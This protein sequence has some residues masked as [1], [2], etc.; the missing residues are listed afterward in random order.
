MNRNRLKSGGR[1][2][3]SKS[4]S[5]SFN[6]KIYYGFEGDTLASALLANGLNVIARSFKYHRPRGIIGSGVE[7]P[8][9]LIE[10]LD[11]GASGNNLCTTVKL[12]EGLNAKSINCW[13]S[14]DFDI[15]ASA[16][17]F[18]K[19]IP[20][21]FYYK[22]FM[23]P[24]W[25]LFEPFIR[26]AAGLAS[27][28]KAPPKAGHFESRNA[29]T[30]FLIIGAG[31]AG[32]L[33]TLMAARSGANVFLIDQNTE[34]GGSLLSSNLNINQ[35]P[36][37]AWVDSVVKEITNMPNVIHL[38]D[39]TAWAYREHNLVIVNQ[40]EVENVSIIERSWRI[41]AKKNNYCYWCD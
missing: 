32:L 29:H 25:H 35:K 3:R 8:A 17:Y 33:A 6:G 16:Q 40:R 41:R 7:D 37:M 28:P 12:K 39:S 38:Q 34:A 30:D 26:I 15:G 21:G 19:L 23:W 5:F 10:L 13:P 22:T 11:E 24:T 9:S 36:A 1:I 27:A 14:V 18:E 2:D 31:P 4:L 20:A